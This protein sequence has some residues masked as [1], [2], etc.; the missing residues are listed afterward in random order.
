MNDKK[1][2]NATHNNVD[3]YEYGIVGDGSYQICSK[4]NVDCVWYDGLGYEQWVF[5]WGLFTPRWHP[6][7]YEKHEHWHT[8]Y[9]QL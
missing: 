9:H 2:K 8:Q 6:Q 1:G 4:I 5:I 7:V 3:S